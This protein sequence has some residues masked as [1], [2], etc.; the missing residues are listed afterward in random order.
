VLGETHLLDSLK[1]CEDLNQYTVQ[2]D[3][4][5]AHVINRH[6]H[7]M[8]ALQMLPLVKERLPETSRSTGAILSHINFIRRLLN[9]KCEKYPSMYTDDVIVQLKKI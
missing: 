8:T 5:F 9:D 7:S 4:I 1:G 3:M 2:E 6:G